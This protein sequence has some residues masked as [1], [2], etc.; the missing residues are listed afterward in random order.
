MSSDDAPAVQ[1]SQE[2]ST[3]PS[4]V[5]TRQEQGDPFTKVIVGMLLTAL[6]LGGAGGY[7]LYVTRD[8]S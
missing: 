5:A 2:P 8:R 7:G 1:L 6:V 4:A 3:S